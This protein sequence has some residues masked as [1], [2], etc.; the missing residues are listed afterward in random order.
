MLLLDTLAAV[1]E[2]IALDSHLPVTVNLTVLISVTAAMTLTPSVV[3][4]IN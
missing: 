1:R 2:A 4:T 3:S